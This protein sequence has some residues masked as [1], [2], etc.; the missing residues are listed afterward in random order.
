MNDWIEISF[1]EVEGKGV[2]M[3]TYL[4]DGRSN[5]GDPWAECIENDEETDVYAQDLRIKL[6]NNERITRLRAYRSIAEYE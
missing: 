1:E 3:F 4:I 2:F 5:C 6:Q